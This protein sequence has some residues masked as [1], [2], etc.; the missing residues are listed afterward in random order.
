MRKMLIVKADHND[1]D[2]LTKISDITDE[3]DF[4]K[5]LPLIEQIAKK[6]K[7]SR[8]WGS[9]DGEWDCDLGK[10]IYFDDEGNEVSKNDIDL[11]DNCLEKLYPTIDAAI[12]DEFDQNYV[13]F[14]TESG[15]PCHNI[16]SIQIYNVESIEDLLTK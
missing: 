10:M 14:D 16:I 11:P 6:E 13:P 8:N 9:L 12:I 3:K 5:F 1:A 4:D 7:H 15:N 2:Y